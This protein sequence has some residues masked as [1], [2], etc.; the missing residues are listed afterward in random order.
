MDNLMTESYI[1]RFERACLEQRPRA[2]LAIR[3]AAREAS[4]AERDRAAGTKPLGIGHRLLRRGQGVLIT[5]GSWLERLAERG[6]EWVMVR[7]ERKPS[8]SHSRW[9]W[10]QLPP[11]S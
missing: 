5:V 1:R 9:S 7:R 11:D 3:L 4:R 10:E 2:A 8:H 6:R